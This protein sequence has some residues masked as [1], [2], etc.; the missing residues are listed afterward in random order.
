M[1]KLFAL[2]L[3]VMLV[4]S[5]ATAAS[6]ESTTTLT[7]TVP[8]ATYTLNIPAN[9]EI[10]F[11]ANSTNIGS[12]SVTEAASFTEGKNLVVT[13]SFDA[14]S[15]HGVDTTIP[16]HLQFNF[17]TTYTENSSEKHSGDSVRFFGLTDGTVTSYPQAVTPTGSDRFDM[18][19]ICLCIET[20]D[21]A[22]A[23]PGEYKS[24]ITF[25]ADVVVEE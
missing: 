7:T 6:A 17:K 22:Q 25:T 18:D 19:S 9:Q 24:T 12:L 2:I 21:W 11:G 16:Y 13:M 20:E 8:A 1:K 10:P 23:L 3:A 5:M 15:C 4:V 14:F